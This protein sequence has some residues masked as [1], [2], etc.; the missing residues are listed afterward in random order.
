MSAVE[1]AKHL[2]ATGA[3]FLDTETTGLGTSDQIVDIAVVDTAGRIVLDSLIK[4]TVP[5]PI[6]A[7]MI[8]GITAAQTASAPSFVDILPVLRKA[9]DSHT[10]VM[11]NAEYD[12]RMMDQ[13]ALA[14]NG[15]LGLR[16]EACCA[17]E[18]YAEYRGDW[19]YNHRSYRWY[20]LEVAARQCGIHYQGGL[21]RALVDAEVTRQIV[22]FIAASRR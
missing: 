16:C 6:A 1:V 5:I 7:T 18:L 21:H 19:D 8:H 10:V 9:V 12:V 4:P 14:H 13:S 17:M 3:L 11:Y 22:M 20:K 15:A 2:I